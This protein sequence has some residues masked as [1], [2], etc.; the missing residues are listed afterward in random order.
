[1][2]PSRESTRPSILSLAIAGLVATA[3]TAAADA[4][5][6]EIVASRSDDV[7]TVAASASTVVV[8]RSAARISEPEL[9]VSGVDD[10]VWASWNE[11][12]AGAAE[13]FTA[14]SKD[15][16]ATWGRARRI[17]FD[18][19]LKAGV[20]VPGENEL[21][22]GEAF[23]AR[24]GATLQI[25]QFHTQ[26]LVPWRAE[27]EKIG[28]EVLSP[29]PHN[30]HIVRMP[31]A[32][33]G[34]VAAL[35]FV[36]WTG[37]F[38]PDF[39]LEAPLRAALEAGAAADGSNR[40]YVLQTFTPGPDEK[41]LLAF[42]VAEAGGTIV[43]ETANGY[44]LEAFLTLDQVAELIHS[45]H[46]LWIER[47]TESGDDMDVARDASG[48][49]YIET[50]GGYDGTGV[51]GEV[52]DSGLQDD[53]QDFDGI[54]FHGAYDLSLH[55]NCTYGINFGNGDR[56]GDGDARALGNVPGA[57]GIFADY[58]FLADRYAHTAE[59]LEPIYEAVYQSNSW[60]GG[61]TL[62]YTTTSMEL[63]DII[64][65][66]DFTIFQ[67]QS[68]AG[69]RMSR[70]QAWSKNIV[71]V[72]GVF[73]RDTV[74]MSDDCWCTGASI[75]PAEDGRIKPD[76]THFY[77]L[78]YTTDVEGP[79]PGYNAGSYYTEFSGTSAATPVVAGLGGLFFQMWADNIY[80]NSP[81][82]PNVFAKRPHA[83]T[84]KAIMINTANQYSFA[85]QGEDLDRFHQGWGL[86]SVQNILDRAAL[87]FIVDESS[88]LQELERDEY[89]FRVSAGQPELK[90]TMVYMDRA[91]T[92]ASTIHRINDVNLRVIAPDG[93]EYWGN[94]GL[95]D[96]NYSV[97]GGQCDT[98]N[99][100]ENV[101]IQSPMA[102]DWEIYV[103]ADEVIQD[104][105]AETPQVD[106]DYA[107]VAWGG[108]QLGCGA[109]PAAPTGVGALGSADNEITVSW[110]G[111]AA[112]YRV[113]RSTGGCGDKLV[114]IGTTT[115]TSYID[116]PVSGGVTFGYVVRAVGE[117]ES[118]DSTC[119][120]ATAPGVCSL[121]PTFAGLSNA[122]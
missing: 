71:S 23:A 25:V 21:T 90:V 103:Y 99:T 17:R 61:R 4:P 18:I 79:D 88:V 107:L 35:S 70:P 72:G 80:G 95:V 101:F 62:S 53:H 48:S 76:L 94:N 112:E 47:W 113:Y 68:N 32:L 46:L 75:G 106:Q 105:H 83:A 28:V 104:V 37:P 82:G 65:L 115:G 69:D 98:L 111:T 100:V 6:L 24:A 85:S 31:S 58:N 2:L 56:D 43:R 93:T 52:M 74:T 30:A 51:S 116:A 122:R 86:P 114:F 12:A 64:W 34:R 117:C 87:T 10:V 49:T 29:L 78:V 109:V 8:R 102:G 15:A 5:V 26:S 42:E 44:L 77:D 14:I 73:H 119:V 13:R 89:L 38:H 54:M 110:S 57:Q 45:E 40:R 7:L 66:N 118:L 41:A 22:P 120:E 50:V 59:L 55:G 92:T 97:A 11:G 20:L 84:A 63:D 39:K 33:S 27:L 3:V 16:G 81:V 108:Q 19:P 60:G 1:M 91:G 9:V 96:G 121:V 67:S 36:R